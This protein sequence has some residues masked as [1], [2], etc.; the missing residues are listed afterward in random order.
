[1]NKI[2]PFAL[3][4]TVIFSQC[5]NRKTSDPQSEFRSVSQTATG[6][7]VNVVM[8][9]YTT[10]MLANGK[11]QTEIRAFVSDSAGREITSANLPL[12]IIVTGDGSISAVK[13]GP[14]M[15]M[16]KINEDGKTTWTSRI[17][18]GSCKMIFKAGTKPDKVKVEVKSGL[19][20][21]GS[22]EIHT[23]DPG[24]KIMKP[25]KE[26]VSPVTKNIEKSIGADISFLPQ[27]ESRGRKFMDNGVETD[28]LKILA[29]HGFNYIRLR[30]FVNPENEK[31]YSP[32]TG[33][34]GLEYT[35]QMAARVKKAGM[36]LLLNFHYSDYWADPQQQN[37]PLSWA[38][39]D[40][41][42]L[43]DSLKLYTKKVLIALRDQG[44]LP[45]MVQIGNEINHGMLWPDGHISNP[46][47]LADLLKA[48]VEAVREVDPSIIVMMHIALGGQNR[49]ATFWLDNM[50]ARGVNFDIIGLSYYPRW[51]GT[52]GDLKYNLN[53]LI[54]RYGKDVN[55]V[56]YSQFKKEVHDIVFNLP[57]NRGE[58]T[59][60][61]EPINSFFDKDGNPT[62]ELLI[63]DEISKKYLTKK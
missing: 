17:V 9:T 6:K 26:Q 20:W 40:F 2:M 32:G 62:P 46:D 27:I 5:N 54:R 60:I 43:R 61:W 14:E 30:I 39:L 21:P 55:V 41:K 59:N 23:I 11:D 37:K 47:N 51:H 38:G 12:E 34:C 4:A 18:D 24:F 53:D 16:L 22:H 57:G 29:D 1:M 7:P 42:T 3:L 13:D 10:T 36:K 28:L 49:E 48:G 45:E 35:K 63:Y 52:L 19:L 56:E 15:A 44:T 8:T 31:G 25:S 50:I 58:G 33:Y